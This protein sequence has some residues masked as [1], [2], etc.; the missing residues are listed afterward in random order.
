MGEI[1]K[2]FPKGWVG[3]GGVRYTSYDKVTAT[4]GY[5][6]VEKYWGNNRAS[7]TIYLTKLSNAGTAPNHRL[8]YNRYYGERVNT[9][10]VAVS[11]GKEHENLGPGLGILRSN[12][13]S[14][15]TKATHWLTESLGVDVSA[16]LHR[17]GTV[18]Y[19]RG[20]YLGLRYRF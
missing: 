17:Q 13:W 5:G 9:V 7:Y 16:G 1:E 2:V 15:N 3:H 4:T 10:G 12:T 18:Y 8:T 6:L 11:F 14:I 20:L 19:R